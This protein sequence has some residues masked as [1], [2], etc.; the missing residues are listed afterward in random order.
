MTTPRILL[1]EDN[2]GD[3][4]LLL[5]AL[6]AT[7]WN[8]DVI[9]LGDG[10]GALDFLFRRKEHAQAVRPDLL[11]MDL[12][13]PC[14]GG[15]EILAAVRADP[16]L[17]SLPVIIFSGSSRERSQMEASGLPGDRYLVKPDTFGGFLNAASAM[18]RI[19][20]EDAQLPPG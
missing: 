2:P 14:V 7:A 1:V 4:L 17:A 8:P 6:Q 18:E 10:M 13:L 3:V 16:A 20:R 19:W 9:H 5:E 12:N 15:R 11:V